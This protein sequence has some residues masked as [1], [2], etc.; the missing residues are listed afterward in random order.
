MLFSCKSPV[1]M[2]SS[3]GS[4]VGIGNIPIPPQVPAIHV[5]ELLGVQCDIK[6]MLALLSGYM[7]RVDDF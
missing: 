1:H 6:K 5:L 3:L 4:V 2:V 7:E